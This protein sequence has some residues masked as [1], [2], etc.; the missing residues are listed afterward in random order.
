MADFS[1][2]QLLSDTVVIEQHEFPLFEYTGL[3]QKCYSAAQRLTFSSIIVPL[4]ETRE[5]SDEKLLNLIVASGYVDEDSDMT[6]R[7]NEASG[8]FYTYFN[9]QPDTDAP[10]VAAE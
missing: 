8:Y 4:S 6:F 3:Y 5:I 10:S 1:K 2:V 9:F 7:I